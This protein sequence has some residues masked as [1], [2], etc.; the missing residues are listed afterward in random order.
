MGCGYFKLP[1]HV[2]SC[3]SVLAIVNW[4]AITS[5]HVFVQ[6]VLLHKYKV[7]AFDA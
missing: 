5:L 1:M 3:L 6:V 4:L 2:L 7:L